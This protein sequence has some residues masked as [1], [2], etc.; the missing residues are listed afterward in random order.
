MSVCMKVSL[1]VILV[2]M[3]SSVRAEVSVDWYQH[4]GDANDTEIFTDMAVDESGTTYITLLDR[5]P[6]L[7][8]GYTTIKYD[9]N[10]I[11][12]WADFYETPSNA[13]DIPAAL[14]V[15]SQGNVYVAGDEG[16]GLVLIK[17]SPIGTIEWIG[18]SPNMPAPIGPEDMVIDDQ[19]NIFVTGYTYGSPDS[20]YVIVKYTPDS[21]IAVWATQY[22]SGDNDRPRLITADKNG[23]VYVS[24]ENLDSHC[25]VTVKYDSNGTWQWASS[26]NPP[27]YTADWANEV[28]D[29]A[30]DST[31]HIYVAGDFKMN[32]SIAGCLVQYA[33]DSNI[34][35][36]YSIYDNGVDGRIE[37]MAI[38]S[39]D[40]IYLTGRKVVD[41]ELA[42]VVLK[43]ASDSNVLV[44]GSIYDACDGADIYWDYG[45][46]VDIGQDG[47]VYVGG[48][49]GYND[50]Q[51]I[52]DFLIL[53]YSP[54]SNI[55][56]W[57]LSYGDPNVEETIGGIGLDAQNN[58]YVSG[59]NTWKYASH[60]DILTFKV[61]E[62]TLPEEPTVYTSPS[63]IRNGSFE[64]D[65]AISDISTFAPRYWWDVN[66]PDT[67]NF[68]SKVTDG[69]STCGD[70]SLLLY[71]DLFAACGAGEMAFVSQDVLMDEVQELTFDV[72]LVSSFGGWNADVR[73][74][75]V[76]LDDQV[77]WNSDEFTPDANDE[78]R[79]MQVL[80]D[81]NDGNMHTLSL[82]MVSDI[83]EESPD[84]V[85]YRVYWDFVKFNLYCDGMGYLREDIDHDCDVDFD[86]FALLAQHWLTPDA[87]YRYDLYEDSE[88]DVFDLNKLA[89][90][91][92]NTTDAA[93][94]GQPNFQTPLLLD[95]D[96]N[97]DGVIDLKDYGIFVE[98]LESQTV[99]NRND[100]NRDGEIDVRD[101]DTLFKDW[102]IK[103]WFYE[104]DE[105]N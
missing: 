104:L 48:S 84:F 67:E 55:P 26:F 70:H 37:A 10:G 95:G 47:Y 75:L 102:L 76:L 12:Q 23:N 82:A 19:D 56:L 36:W 52:G 3:V 34:P 90:H 27:G 11:E 79:D 81:V 13:F 74:A 80:L 71:S 42:C 78:L 17:Y 63:L 33:P 14:D 31:G 57:W 5:D 83:D 9:S 66:L 38:D 24:G 20:N 46:S 2:M 53:K 39:H 6:V 97:D 15:D 49:T 1:V 16:N 93:Q 32:G 68:G 100:I 60:S 40:D 87:A 50:N 4:Y 62:I 45:T 72:R 94:C 35:Q 41:S 65:G 29:I 86:D 91:W 99:T 7:G 21:N 59:G 51:N 25:Y 89:D 54:D 64:R 61:I 8:Y 77:I 103:S 43:Y 98:G 101:M 88:V 28:R 85:E 30:I 69:W 92:L 18:N 96:L 58:I 44:W 105:Y 73:T 22:D